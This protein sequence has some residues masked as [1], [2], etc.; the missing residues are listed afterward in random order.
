MSNGLRVYDSNGSLSLN[1]S[2]RL[3]KYISDMRFTLPA[4]TYTITFNI[5]G[6]NALE[7]FVATDA[8]SEVYTDTIKLTRGGTATFDRMF[9]LTI[10][11]Y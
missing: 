4:N 9:N 8:M 11:K 10:F 2:D 7:Y 6:I 3:T 5:P 1:I